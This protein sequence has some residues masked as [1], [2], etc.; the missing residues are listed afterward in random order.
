MTDP[1][2]TATVQ[3]A[4]MTSTFEF[5]LRTCCGLGVSRHGS[6]YAA[7]Q[8]VNE[9]RHA[10]YRRRGD[11]VY[12][13]RHVTCMT[14][15][16][17]HFLIFRG[18]VLDQRF[19][20]LSLSYIL[21]LNQPDPSQ[22]TAPPEKPRECAEALQYRVVTAT[23]IPNRPRTIRPSVQ[24]RQGRRSRPSPC[25][26]TIRGQAR[27][28]GDLLVAAARQETPR[29]APLRLTSSRPPLRA[30]LIVDCCQLEPH[31]KVPNPSRLCQRRQRPRI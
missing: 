19:V 28:L 8:P 20:S 13:L 9:R 10:S 24:Q 22:Q 18:A 12:H 5:I 14:A 17:L 2:D 31:P 30:P 27:R 11:K 6:D 16:E 1:A 25:A 26:S 7:V 29:S 15:S 23:W 4:A 21:G 3:L